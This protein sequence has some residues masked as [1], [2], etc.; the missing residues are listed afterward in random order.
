M[1]TAAEFVDALRRFRLLEPAQLD[2]LT[3]Q[4]PGQPAKA[5]ALARQ[6]IDRGWLTPYQANLLLQG[7]GPELVL[8]A[9]VLLER[10]GEGGMGTVFKARHGALGR[11]VALKVIRKDRLA[12]WRRR[13]ALPAARSGPPPSCTTP[14]SSRPTTPTR[15]VAPLP[16]H[17][18]RR[19]HRPG[20]ARQGARAAAGG[21][22]ACEYV[23]QAALG[24]QHAH[25]RGMVHRD[26]KPANLMVQ[27]PAGRTAAGRW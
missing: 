22:V 9:Y 4:L 11:I 2:E 27:S 21:A 13:R 6:L 7:R 26:I 19:G 15:P 5:R 18:V 12:E 3:R 23:R 20:Q 10:L 1:F 14:T 24:L 8:G 17:G 16:G 25:E